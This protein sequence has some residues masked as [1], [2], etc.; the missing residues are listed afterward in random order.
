MS[1]VTRRAYN[2]NIMKAR[3]WVMLLLAAGGLAAAPGELPP[4]VAR[5][6][7][8]ADVHPILLSRCAGCH[9]GLKP[10]AGLAVL[11]RADILR[12]GQHGAAIVSGNSAKS[13]LILRV[14]GMQ[15]PRMPAGGPPLS[16]GEIGILRAWIDQG[17]NWNPP[18]QAVWK[19]SLALRVPT[20][21]EPVL[22]NPLDSFL[23]DYFR[24]HNIIAPPPVA[25]AVFARR[26]WLDLWGVVPGPEQLRTFEQVT[27]SDKR[28]RLI[29]ELLANRKN[30][31]EH[32]ISFWNDL[33]RNDEGVEYAG[34]RQSITKWLRR[35]L[36]ENLPYDRFVST[37]LNPERADDP[38]GYL[39]GVNWRGDI[40]AS[41]TPPMQAAQNSAQVFLGVNLK[42]NSC[43]DSFISRW[44]LKDA[45]GLA[46]FFSEQEL[47]IHRCDIATGETS[48]PRFLYPELGG[49]E[50]GA[51]AAAR[52]AAVARLFTTKENGRFART[53]V[54]RIWKDLMGR[55][56]VGPVDDMDAEPWD[57][58]LLDWLSADFVAHGY[59]IGHLLRR[60]MTSA[61]YQLP[62]VRLSAKP[63]QQYVF[64]GP[65]F[66]RL[67]AEQ[68]SDS[69]SA[70]TGE[71][72]VMAPRLAGEGVYAREWMF[73]TTALSTALGRPIRD[74][75]I[76]E[77]NDDATTLQL[78]ELV[79]GT[80]LDKMLYRGAAR[81]LGELR[82]AP[83]NLFDSGVV[84]SNKAVVDIDITGVRRLWLLLTDTDSYNPNL[85]V[86]GWANA[87]LIGPSGATKLPEFATGGGF[88]RRMLQIKNDNFDD[89]M[90][91]PV[92]SRLVCDIAGKGYTRF[93]A[94]V[95]V[96]KSSVRDDIGPRVRF[97]V[98]SEEPDPDQLVRVKPETPVPAPDFP[99]NTEGLIKLLYRSALS[100]DPDPGELRAARGFLSPKPTRDGLQ[101][102]LWSVFMSPEFQF[103]R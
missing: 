80:T 75:V 98:F 34:A 81:M 83:A 51:P 72:R 52:R 71:W 56:L 62:A 65:L 44:K 95:G 33:L 82:P 48:Q 76:T 99:H 31:A 14:S 28:E 97:F 6:V 64:R 24:R 87:E 69:I 84:T 10:Q 57:P 77:R 96:D 26:A 7:D 5:T 3:G 1:M 91:S 68:F 38:M 41:Q 93:H 2:Q 18:G 36:E 61:A 73:K 102:L 66:R 37:L 11:N 94:T 63:S 4:P 30:Y 40:S 101:D 16:A 49:I 17:A 59:D 92:P 35:A 42:C 50:P 54:N 88:E 12:G 58:D 89:A 100:R 90:V 25:D 103:I 32:W 60:I 86:A 47:A 53:L 27:R 13:L 55:G 78:L 20:I 74:Q 21:P 46:S 39:V 22:A 85:I 79:N 15:E 19:P 29:D 23:N 70:I 8:F 45:Y 67:T 43:H 9:G